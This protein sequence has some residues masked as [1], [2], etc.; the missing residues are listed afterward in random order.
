MLQP[1]PRVEKR[2]KTAANPAHLWPIFAASPARR[3]Q[4]FVNKGPASCSEDELNLVLSRFRPKFVLARF[5]KSYVRWRASL[6][7]AA[8]SVG[9][10]DMPAG[11]SRRE[12]RG[13]GVVAGHDL[14][15]G[16]RRTDRRRAAGRFKP[17]RRTQRRRGSGRGFPRVPPPRARTAVRCR[18]KSRFA[19]GQ[20][21]GCARF[22]SAWDYLARA[23][24]VRRQS[25]KRQSVKSH[26]AKCQSVKRQSVKRQSA[27]SQP[28]ECPSAKCREE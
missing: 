13:E 2:A 19:A 18:T 9:Q 22:Q 7:L 10:A 6:G 26:T 11:E 16:W 23:Q 15:D 28:T 14:A 25:I 5:Q 20:S 1:A 12:S 21:C 17:S 3:P 24:S 8:H 4:A 27:N